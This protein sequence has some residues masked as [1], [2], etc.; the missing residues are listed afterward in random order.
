MVVR[1]FRKKLLLW[2]ALL[3]VCTACGTNS[4][5]DTYKIGV[6]PSWRGAEL[7]GKE[8]EV[9]AFSTDLLKQVGQESALSLDLVTYSWDVL[10]SSLMERQCQAILGSMRPYIFNAKIYDFSDIYLQTGPVLV[11]SSLS[12]WDSLAQLDGKEIAVI[13]GGQNELLLE[14]YPKIL[15]RHYG[16]I[17]QALEDVVANVIDGVLL[18]VLIASSYVKDLYKDRLK[19]ATAPLIDDGLR[20]ITLHN[21]SPAL[22]QAFNADLKKL[23]SSGQYAELQKK[24]NLPY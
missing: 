23:Q 7:L 2:M 6:D 18:N 12:H 3:C 4:S 19:I 9:L 1:I 24:W 5:Q 22:L 8:K 21:Q 17:P 14:A 13:D 20:L 16:S 10:L 15:I 11:T